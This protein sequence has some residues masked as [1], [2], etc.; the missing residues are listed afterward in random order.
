MTVEVFLKLQDI[1]LLKLEQ[2]YL[3]ITQKSRYT[4]RCFLP[5]EGLGGDFEDLASRYDK[6]NLSDKDK[7]L[8]K[9]VENEIVHYFNIHKKNELKVVDIMTNIAS[10]MLEHLKNLPRD[11]EDKHVVQIILMPRTT[12]KRIQK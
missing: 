9:K 7:E 3:A 12:P 4:R 2:P 10:E 1:M 5:L 11:I 6:N 8:M